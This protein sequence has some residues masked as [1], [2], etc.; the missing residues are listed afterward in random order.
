MEQMN[1]TPE[2]TGDSDRNWMTYASLG[3]GAFSL[4]AW[5]LPICGCPMSLAAG[6]LGYLG[7]E[8]D[9]R[10]L[11]YVGIGLG[12]LGLLLTI[13]NAAVGAYLGFTGQNN[14]VN[15]LLGQ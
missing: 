3:L 11:S 14:L 12:A 7:L 4:C 1:A 5:L 9:Q 6:I 8:S 13:G 15:T 2:G 10:T